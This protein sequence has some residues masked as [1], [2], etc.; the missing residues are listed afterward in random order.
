MLDR[1]KKLFE[2]TGTSGTQELSK[3]SEIQLAAAALLVESAS[4]DG[5]FDEMERRRISSLMQTHFSLN[6]AETKT[7]ITQAELAAEGTGQL[8][9]FTKIVKD[10]YDE[11]DRINVI[12]MLWEVAFAD[13]N[14]DAFEKNFIQRVAGLLFVSDKDRGLAKKRVMARLGIHG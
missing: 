1:I 3:S 9:G 5:L 4:I 7:L 12:D 13:G 10:R 14:V 2:A 11:C 8:Y 6:N